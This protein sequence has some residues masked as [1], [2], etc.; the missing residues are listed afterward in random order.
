MKIKKEQD[1]K[2]RK[3]LRKNGRMHGRKLRKLVKQATIPQKVG[4]LYPYERARL[5]S[6]PCP[7]SNYYKQKSITRL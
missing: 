4:V 5:S 7:K 6:G 3:K 2:R 1:Q